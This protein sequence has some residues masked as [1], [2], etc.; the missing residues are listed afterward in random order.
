MG[1]LSAFAEDFISFAPID[2]C[3]SI[4]FHVFIS[5]ELVHTIYRGDT[6]MASFIRKDSKTSHEVGCDDGEQVDPLVIEELGAEFVFDEAVYQKA[7]ELF[8]DDCRRAGATLEQLATWFGMSRSALGRRYALEAPPPVQ[9]ENERYFR[10][11]RECISAK[12]VG[13]RELV[14]DLGRKAG[15]SEQ[16]AALLYALGSRRRSCATVLDEPQESRRKRVS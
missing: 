3:K 11:L 14:E 9:P 2:L 15:T 8:M 16:T 10:R 6:R 13:L 7:R 1:I 4:S 12:P 5:A